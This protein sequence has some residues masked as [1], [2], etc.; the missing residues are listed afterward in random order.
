MSRATAA[1]ALALA[2]AV[3]ALAGCGGG[4]MTLEAEFADAR[5]LAERG[6]VTL[7]DVRVGRVTDVEL[8]RESLVARVTMEVEDD[9]DLPRRV[10]ARLRKTSLLGEHYVELVPHDDAGGTFDPDRVI[11]DTRVAS[12]LETLMG[13]AG[14]L[15]AVLA[16]DR[17]ARAID[18]GATGLGGRG[19]QLDRALDHTG[20]IARRYDERTAELTAVLDDL[21]RLLSVTAAES[22][23]HA[24]A[25]AALAEATEV[26]RAED[27]RLVDAL[28]RLGDLS[29]ELGALAADHR[30]DLDDALL[31]L[32]AV[33]G[34]IAE[35]RDDLDE[36]WGELAGHNEVILDGVNLEQAQVFLDMLVCGSNDEPGHPVRGCDDV[37]QGRS[38]PPRGEPQPPPEPE[39]DPRP[40]PSGEPEEG[41]R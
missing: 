16:G 12:D 14:E 22:D 17:L 26:L 37:P 18:A 39:L 6:K 24:D 23:T 4:R 30:A 38:R 7:S 11:T 31:N 33:T 25:V 41:E 13:R 34:A 21:E 29:A 19:P 36:M 28:A 8:D 35:R 20:A 9:L 3:L 32:Q 5:T 1:L 15:V 2:G 27:D 40:D 10:S